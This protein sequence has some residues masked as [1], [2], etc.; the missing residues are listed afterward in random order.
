MQRQTYIS[1]LFL[2][3]GLLLIIK[4]SDAQSYF[5]NEFRNDSSIYNLGAFVHQFSDS[6]GYLVVGSLPKPGG[7]V[8]T[9][10][11]RLN[12]LGDTVWTKLYGDSQYGQAPSL[13]NYISIGDTNFVFTGIFSEKSSDS[14]RTVLF[15]I[16]SSGNVLW[17]YR[18][19][20]QGKQPPPQTS[21]QLLMGATLLQ[22]VQLVGEIPI[23]EQ[24]HFY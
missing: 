5:N 18:F 24:V 14:S 9:R 8:Y 12:N 17:D 7:V 4:K 13:G 16:D 19:G 11:L 3:I 22:A 2:F 21:K 10:F 15:K 20:D 23:A 6:S 1:I